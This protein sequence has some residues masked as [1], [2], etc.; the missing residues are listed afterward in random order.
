M[1][2]RGRLEKFNYVRRRSLSEIKGD[3]LKAALKARQ[4]KGRRSVTVLEVL[5]P[6][7]LPTCE[8]CGKE[9]PDAIRASRRTC[10]AT[11]RKAMGRTTPRVEELL[12]AALGD[13]YETC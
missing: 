6:P 2:S 8:H 4:V 10:S 5:K 11:C 7:P 12:M 1:R 13:A 3:R 9:M